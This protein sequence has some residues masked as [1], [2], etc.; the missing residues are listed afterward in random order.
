MIATPL[1][2]RACAPATDE[3]PA[4]PHEPASMLSHEATTYLQGSAADY[5][6]IALFASGVAL[7]IVG[8]RKNHHNLPFAAAIMLLLSSVEASFVQ[9]T[10]EAI[11]TAAE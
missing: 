2:L 1:R 5:L 6:D 4:S 10:A 8:C 3:I 9:G 11:T 7:P